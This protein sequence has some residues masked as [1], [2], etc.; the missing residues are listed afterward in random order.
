[1]AFAAASDLVTMTIANRVP[2]VLAVSFLALAFATGMPPAVIG[3]HFVVGLA[4]LLVTFG[5]FA[6]GWMGGGDAKLVAATALWL[7]PTEAMTQYLLLGAL[8]GG[9]LTLGLL[10][11]RS[12]LQPVTTIDFVDR[13][14]EEKTG[15][16]Y[17][18]AL[19]FAGLAAY[20]QSAWID[21]AV[22]GAI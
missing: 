4:A 3:L 16:P 1:M 18:I 2:I 15:I 22:A 20:S 6:A 7:G 8:L 13:L 12:V 9:A 11:L 19:G 14:L 5:C 21:L 10:S 17:G